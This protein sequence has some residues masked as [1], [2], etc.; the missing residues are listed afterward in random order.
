MGSEAD[1]DDAHSALT[2]IA[3]G[4]G[5]VFGGRIA[6]LALG[7][8]T[9][10]ITARLL[11]ADAYGGFVLAS[12]SMGVTVLFARIGLKSGLLRKLPYHE[13]DH[14]QAR[15]VL[16]AG[17]QIGVATGILAGIAL[18]ALAPVV[19][20]RVFNDPEVTPLIRIAAAGV[21]FSVLMTIA[22]S[23]ARALRD[24]KPHVI[25]RQIA[26]TALTAV[27][28]TALLVAGYDAVGAIAG[29]V[30]AG[31]ISSVLALYL[32][33]RTLPF[34][35]RGPTTP[36]GVELLAFS[37][38]LLLAASAD[39]ALAQTDTV[40]VGV[41]M[42]SGDV[43]VYNV[44]YR[45]HSLGLVFFYPVTFLLPPILTR[46]M[47]HDQRASAGRTYKIT[48]K[49]MTLLT[50]PLFLL[51]FLFPE[52]IIGTAF[53]GA[54]TDG[55]TALRILIVPIAVTTVLGANGSALVALGHNRINLYGNGATAVLNV[56]LNVLLV[57]RLGL[58][59]AA[60]ATAVSL[61]CRDLFYT[62]LLYRWYRIHSLS[63]S[64]L[65]PILAVGVLTPVGYGVFH[66]LFDPTFLSVTA[67]GLAFLVLYLP[68]VVRLGAIQA[69]D[70]EVFDRLEASAGADLGAVRKYIRVLT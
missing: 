13:D 33:Y 14:P 18:Y 61:I 37:L 50:L 21:P 4:A 41:Y 49:W 17:V 46:L 44:A 40:L 59:G 25:V 10:V 68:L 34:P 30:I 66:R 64:M 52:V 58:F 26:S 62:G 22:L 16:K 24:A 56:V 69:A 70:V 42:T 60:T 28:V 5:L 2:T 47:E 1:S 11:G 53:G 38:P 51:V 67:I 57:P 55:A 8:A 54:Y 19:A 7:F 65:R 31:A 48:T 20:T 12:M 9:Q 36:M 15:G 23:T 29:T 27:F 45:L 35:I 32:A 6:K 43:G 63:W 3:G 39:W